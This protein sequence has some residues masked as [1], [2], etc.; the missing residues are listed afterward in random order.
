MGAICSKGTANMSCSPYASRSAGSRVSRITRSAGPTEPAS[1]ASSS[2]WAVSAPCQMRRHLRSLHFFAPWLACL[3][4][5]QRHHRDDC[6]QPAGEVRHVVGVRAAQ[7]QPSFL[8]GVL[9]VAKRTE[10]PERH[11]PGGPGSPLT[12]RRTLHQSTPTRFAVAV[13]VTGRSRKA[14]ESRV[15]GGA[16]VDVPVRGRRSQV[17]ERKR[18]APDGR[19]STHSQ[20]P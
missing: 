7:P 18:K 1:N 9:G 12:D 15:E 3:Q 16:G 6:G 10:D 5:V 19:W 11:H 4:Q 13:Q 17:C 14:G 2:G 8:N 20:G